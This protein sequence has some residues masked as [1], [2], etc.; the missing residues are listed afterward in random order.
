MR[1]LVFKQIVQLAHL[2]LIAFLAM[3]MGLFAPMICKYHGLLWGTVHQHYDHQM[4]QS[5][6]SQRS[7]IARHS[8][9]TTS[10]IM[11]AFVASTPTNITLESLF[12]L[13]SSIENR[14]SFPA[15]I[16]VQPAEQP[17]RLRLSV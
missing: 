17:P 7:G 5:E 15:L 9:V 6:T 14:I 2:W 1:R 8:P 16:D 11:S 12:E 10:V 3:W 4:E 13:V